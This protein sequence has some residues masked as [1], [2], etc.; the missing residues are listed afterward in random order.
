MTVTV[1]RAPQHADAPRRRD[2]RVL[3]VGG[4]GI[5]LALLAGWLLLGRGPGSAP[6]VDPAATGR[7]T[8]CQ[9]GHAVTSGSTKAFAT[10][11]V[12]AGSAT[13]TVALF[14]YQPHQGVAPSAWSGLQLTPTAPVTGTASLALTARDTTLAQ[15]VA[16]Y[17]AYWK[18]WVQLRLYRAATG[19]PVAATY[20]AV[21][22][23]ISGDH[24]SADRPG[25]AG[26]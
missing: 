7:L 1:D 4:A 25:H 23:H 26:C 15:F 13:G 10:K 20:D 22:L 2:R 18:G 11:V 8:L 24:W 17:P 9:G 16:A 5:V 6:Y 21:D 19:Q 14:G 3:L 12:G